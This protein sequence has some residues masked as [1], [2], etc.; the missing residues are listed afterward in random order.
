[1][2]KSKSLFLLSLI[3]FVSMACLYGCG[4]SSD[5]FQATGNNNGNVV[6]NNGTVQL[7]FALLRSVP[8]NVDTFVFRGL[9]SGGNQVFTQ[10]VAKAA[11]VTL[12]VPTSVTTLIIDY[13]AAGVVIGRATLSITVNA[14][15]TTVVNDP[16]FV[17][18]SPSPSPSPTPTGTPTPS[19]TGQFHLLGVD[20]S[21][22]TPS[23]ASGMI[24]LD[25][26]GVPS[27]SFTITDANG[28]TTNFTANG[29]SFGT[30][31]GD[32]SGALNTNLSN[33]PLNG[34]RGS[35]GLILA[36]GANGSVETSRSLMF[37]LI[38]AISG[39][40]QS[41]LNGTFRLSNIHVGTQREGT[42]TGTVTFAGNGAITGG[43]VNHID[44]GT[45]TIAGGGYTVASNGAVSMTWI[46]GDGSTYNVNGAL[47]SNGVLNFAGSGTAGERIFGYASTDP[48]TPCTPADLPTSPRILGV[49]IDNGAYWA[50]PTLNN[51]SVTGGT[52]NLLNK[53]ANFPTAN[54]NTGSFT[55]S[56]VCDLVGSFGFS[57]TFMN[58]TFSDFAN[59]SQSISSPDA[60]FGSGSG[61]NG[62]TGP[63]RR[64]GF[65]VTVR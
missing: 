52:I 21:F 14:G 55:F 38:P 11:Q 6:N 28:G 59:I 8:A 19:P 58:V 29:G 30:G 37:S 31:T 17:D 16:D 32:F 1:M 36:V 51:G 33:F 63:A 62:Q 23:T 41:S 50:D 61:T 5:D 24:T 20:G 64:V 65:S 54:I 7:N 15:Q 34:T 40:S 42:S 3:A 12:T 4:S 44:A 46:L 9:D 18:V 10:T 39:G 56:G 57:F 26:S 22:M 45:L 43:Q 13:Q 27:G 35:N 2:A 60:T 53:Q 47:S 25:S 49:L 48:A